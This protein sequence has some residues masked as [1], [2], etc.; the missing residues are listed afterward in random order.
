MST[1]SRELWGNF[2]GNRGLDEQRLHG[3]GDINH[4]VS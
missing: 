2:V 4:S 3:S 1:L